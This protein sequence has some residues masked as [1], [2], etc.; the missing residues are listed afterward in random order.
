MSSR[1]AQIFANL[2]VRER[3]LLELRLKHRGDSGN[4][5][6][7]IRRRERNAIVPLSFAQQRLWLI[8]QW[9]PNSSAYNISGGFRL[10]GRL[11]VGALEAALNEIVNRH[12]S[13]RTTLPVIDE[14]PRQRVAA[15]MRLMMP[16][17]NLSEMSAEKQ[18]VESRRLATQE[19]HRSFDLAH[20]PLIYTSLLYLGEYEHVLLLTMHHIVSDGWS[21]GVFLRELRTLYTAFSA[22]ETSPLPELP[23][24]Y[25]DFAIWQREWLKGDVLEQQLDYWRAQLAGAPPLLSLPSDRPRPPVQNFHGARE[26]LVLSETIS[27]TMTGLGQVEGATLF[28]TMLAAFKAWLW[29]YSGQEDICIGTPISNRTRSE[30]EGLIG[31]FINMLVLRTDLSGNP[32]FRE[33]LGRVRHSTLQAYTHQDVPFEKL[34]EELQPKRNL[35]HTPLF[36]VAFAL[37]NDAAETVEF[38]DLSLTALEGSDSNTSKFDLTLFLGHTKGGMR[39]S[40]VYNPELFDSATVKRMLRHFGN[41]LEGIVNDPD[42]RLSDLTLLS[43]G[44]RYQLLVEANQTQAAYPTQQGVHEL[45]AAQAERTPEAT[46]VVFEGWH[47]SYAELNRRANQLAHRLQGMG[48]GPDALV[49]IAM[50]KSL[51][52]LVGLLGILKAGAAYVPLDPE[53]PQ[54][55]LSFVLEDTAAAVL[56]TQEKLVARF[57]THGAQVIEIDRQ[58]EMIAEESD[59]N[60]VTTAGPD[61]LAYV[62]YTSGSTGQPK[63]AMVTHRALVNYLTWAAKYYRVTEGEGAPVHSPVGFDLTVTSLFTPL[64]VGQQIIVLRDRQGIEAID[65]ALRN[66]RD[67][68][69][70][71][72]TPSHLDAISLRLPAE[73]VRG[74]SR[75]I[76]LGGEELSAETISFWRANAPKTRIVNEYGPTETVVGCCIYEVPAGFSKT[77]PVPIGEP[78]ANTQLYV[79]DE[80]L[81]PVPVGVAGELYI[82]GDGLARGYLN[83]PEQT[84][85][86][87]T[88]HPFALVPGTRLYKTGDLARRLADGNLEY[89]GRIDNQV[90]VRGFRIELGEI[91]SLLLQHP[92]VREAVATAR[93]DTPGDK[94]LIAYIVAG[95]QEPAPS[96]HDLRE[97][98]KEKLPEYMMPSSFVLLDVLPLTPNGKVD[99]RALPAPDRVRAEP[100]ETFVAPRDTL[101]LQLAHM[102]EDLLGIHPIGVT[103]N[104][105]EIGGHSLLAERLMAGVRKR[106][107]PDITISVFLQEPTIDHL[108]QMVRAVDGT[109]QW[110]PLVPIQPHGSELPLFCIHSLS[111]DV[112]NYYNLARHLGDDRPVYGLQAVHPSELA[113]DHVSLEEMAAAYLAVIAEVQP[114]GPY[115]LVGYSFGCV[116]A[117]EIAQQLKRRGEDICS[118]ALVD[119]ISPLISQNVEERGEAYMLAGIARD[120]G[121]TSG[122]DFQLPHKMFAQL[123]PEEALT[124]ILEKMKTAGLIPADVGFPWL[125][126]FMLGLKTRMSAIKDYQPQPY[127]GVITLLRSS[128]VEP[129]SAKAWLEVGVD[130][131][132]A[133]RGWN[134]LSSEPLE[135]LFVPGYHA[136][137][138]HKPYVEVLA[139]K[140]KYCIEKSEK[141]C[142]PK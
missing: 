88:P 23:I 56:L 38:A 15:S 13:L 55:R 25:A 51:D 123:A 126:K 87:F 65:N 59:A 76:I 138:F 45:I 22:G 44:E 73:A 36:Q 85:E 103:D 68:S 95:T 2:S 42:A 77:G 48:V 67:F 101:E 81:Q 53:Y 131:R 105:F 11:N 29:R 32:T 49:I 7:T 52:M 10:R 134:E 33:L 26:T 34:V 47:M 75:V 96:P 8:Q 17:V 5:V 114:T 136:T 115:H 79:M 78:I 91:E 27:D 111:G 46:A 127:E 21:M 142:K 35:S 82:G 137:M 31:L 86:K 84:A 83:R 39:A 108:A 118:L 135:I 28:M 139:A 64:L 57:P 104:F 119:G 74:C 125:Q 117:F 72:I 120:M 99:R 43:E 18:A 97:Y 1:A 128:E 60:P 90:K 9:N 121:R 30:T 6:P 107:S 37:H 129:E 140:L 109:I 14:Q 112:L 93:E 63:G 100:E 71:K 141:R 110:S 4:L 92:A 98:L 94:R 69:F 54:E 89:L 3:T 124:F 66:C 19:A 12:E 106:F 58:W 24:Q 41:L 20:G 62:I 133:T 50:E 132:E 122:V 70:F 130:V 61:N 80:Q 102:C 113:E 16:V 116:V 40:F